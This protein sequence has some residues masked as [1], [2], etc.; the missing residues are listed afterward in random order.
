VPRVAA[1]PRLPESTMLAVLNALLAVAYSFGTLAR[2]SAPPSPG[3]VSIVLLI[4]SL[5]P[6]WQGAFGLVA[7][8]LFIGLLRPGLLP[9]GHILGAG[10]TTI[11]ATAI[12]IGWGFSTPRP[13]VI[14]ALAFTALIG[15]H[16]A[17]S[18]SYARGPS[19][20]SRKAPRPPSVSDIADRVEPRH[21]RR[22]G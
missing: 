18:V 1:V 8:L 16:F 11:Y 3:R 20:T 4:D 12:W 22:G 21:A 14:S 5:G 2:G 15:W 13:S 17:L 6:V 19:L 10:V 9:I 7:A